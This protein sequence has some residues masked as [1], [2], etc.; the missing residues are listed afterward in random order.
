MSCL[1]ADVPWATLGPAEQ[2]FGASSRCLA[3]L[4]AGTAEVPSDGLDLSSPRSWKDCLQTV[5]IL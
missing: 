3:K 5:G 4:W 1:T 2:N